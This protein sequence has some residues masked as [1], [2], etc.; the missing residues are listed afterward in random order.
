MFKDELDF[1]EEKEKD[2]PK[3]DDYQGLSKKDL[4]IK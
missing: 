1:E 3:N 2:Q 4:E